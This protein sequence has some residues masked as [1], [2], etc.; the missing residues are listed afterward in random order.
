MTK[1]KS[2]VFLDINIFAKEEFTSGLLITVR[3]ILKRIS[4]NGGNVNILSIAQGKRSKYWNSEHKLGQRERN[5]QGIPVKEILLKDPPEQDMTSYILAIRKLLHETKPSLI[6]M[7]TPG[8]FLDEVNIR[9]LKETLSTGAKVV[10]LVVDE[11]YPTTESHPKEKIERYYNLLRKTDVIVN[12][13]RIME[14]LLKRTGVKGE[15]FPNLFPYR[16]IVSKSSKHDFITLINHHPIKGREIF[17]SVAKK[18]PSKKFMVV[19]NWPDVP[20]YIPPAKNVKFSRFIQDTS[21]L[22][23]K[24]R[25][26]LVPSL[27]EEGPA[28]VIMEALINGIP[29]V[30]HKIGSIS[31]I[32]GN[33]VHYIKPPSKITPKLKGTI[34]YPIISKS[35][36]ERVSDNFVSAINKIDQSQS[37]WK[38]QSFL[39]KKYAKKYCERAEK[40][41]QPFLKHW[42]SD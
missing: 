8:V 27:C 40:E 39:S 22:Y 16:D 15:L 9:S 2:A 6:I 41:F 26:L 20:T 35:E 34:I 30:A 3:E 7:N 12:S 29:V 18:M 23:S 10:T 21:E 24:I 33:Y 1:N 36:L 31:E 4:K 11:L 19:E 17:N 28:R 25:I 37:T 42:F 32:G 38:K 5:I 13:K 14:N